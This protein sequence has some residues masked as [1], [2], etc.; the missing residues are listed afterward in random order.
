MTTLPLLLC[1][2]LAI[3][4]LGENAMG[5]GWEDGDPNSPDVLKV[6]QAA[7]AKQKKSANG[8]KIISVRGQVVAGMRYS[9]KFTY[10]EGGNAVHEM[11]VVDVPW[12]GKLIIE[13]FK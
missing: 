1:M 12:E 2:L 9:I 8:L 13:E 4:V 6:A 10:A 7:L 3:P 11:T 5:G